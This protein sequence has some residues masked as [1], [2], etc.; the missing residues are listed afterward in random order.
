MQ[1]FSLNLSVNVKNIIHSKQ[2]FYFFST[3]D[4]FERLKDPLQ[5]LMHQPDSRVFY[6][7]VNLITVF[8]RGRTVTVI[9]ISL[10]LK[11]Y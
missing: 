7:Y 3:C 8:D 1:I 6:G 9:D 2:F 5:I 4:L 11:E 10:R